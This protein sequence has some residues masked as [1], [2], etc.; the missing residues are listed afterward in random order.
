MK[1]K[2][3]TTVTLLFVLSNLFSQVNFSSSNLPII[4]IKT[5][6]TGIPDEPKVPATMQI[7][8]NGPGNMNHID[9]EPNDYNGQI[10]IELRGQTSQFF[11]KKPYG[12]ETWDDLGQDQNVS[13]LGMPKEN[14]WVFHN[15]FSDKSLIRNA[16]SYSIA[17]KIMDYAPRV[18]MVEM[19][20]NDDYR[21]V[22]LLTEKIKRDKNRVNI[23]KLTPESEDVSGGY[24]LKF[25]KGDPD[26]V[27]FY[28]LLSSNFRATT[29]NSF[30]VAL[31]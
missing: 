27:G 7:I 30:S 1:L 18:R 6:N 22:Y 20:L 21:G 9:D 13:I 25:D 10:G 15:P 24:I 16:I 31:P 17:G 8:D 26:E 23:T 5:N 3:T 29:R 14:D 11:P 12:F 4:I 28:L 2:V 19:V